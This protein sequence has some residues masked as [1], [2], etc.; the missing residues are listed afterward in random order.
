MEVSDIFT[1]AEKMSEYRAVSR[2][3]SDSTRI[4]EYPSG[5]FSGIFDILTFESKKMKGGVYEQMHGNFFSSPHI[6]PERAV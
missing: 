6:M 3:V 5:G 4:S 2:A 1:Y